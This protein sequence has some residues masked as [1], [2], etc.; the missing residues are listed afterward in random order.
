MQAAEL[1]ERH[2][3]ALKLSH[4]QTLEIINRFEQGVILFTAD[5]NPILF[6]QTFLHY[7]PQLESSEDFFKDVALF[8]QKHH[9]TGSS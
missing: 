6:N 2:L 9:A 7:Y 3:K 4:Q 8:T 5:A 1:E